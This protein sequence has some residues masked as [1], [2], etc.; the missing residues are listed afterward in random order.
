MKNKIA[1]V[2]LMRK[3]SKRF[4]NKVLY[5]IL[6]KPLYMWT[7]DIALQLEYPYYFAHDYDQL[8][9]PEHENL[10]V[11]KRK[12]EYAG[13][14][15][16]TCEEIKS[17]NID[18]DIYIFLQVTSPFRDISI[19]KQYIQ[20]FIEK[21][22]VCA[23]ACKL[24]KPGYWYSAKEGNIKRLNFNQKDRTDNGC[25]TAFVLKE[26]GSFYMFK[27]EQLNKKHILDCHAKDFDLFED[28]YNIDIDHPFDARKLEAKFEN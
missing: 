27:K 12:E 2:T 4:P 15:H 25:K 1:I 13:D 9:L 24:H 28:K 7:V 17:F 6:G 19:L 21:D 3:G 14:T 8:E 11:I 16:K 20:R 23:V 22:F 10:H 26:T 5:P 18:A